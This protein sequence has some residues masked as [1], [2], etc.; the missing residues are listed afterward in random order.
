[1]DLPTSNFGS[2]SLLGVDNSPVKNLL[3]KFTVTGVGSRTVVSAKLRLYCLDPAT[4]GGEFHRV[5]D[6]TWTEGSVT[7]NT[8]PAADSIILGTLGS[9][10][11]GTWYEVD[12]TSL[13]TG[14]G[15]FSLRANSNSTNGADYS[16]KEGTAGFAPQLV[17]TTA[18]NATSTASPT[19]TQMPT[20]TPTPTTGTSP[21]NHQRHRQVHLVSKCISFIS[22]GKYSF[23]YTNHD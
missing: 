20:S 19:N 7:W 6:T 13:V 5:A 14:D 3:L 17:I 21:S 12:V 23:V 18:S 2:D 8:A 10:V 22:G 16:S 1:M 11:S 15:I 9:V 4:F